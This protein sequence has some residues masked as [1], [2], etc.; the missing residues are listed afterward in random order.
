MISSR[1]AFF[2]VSW[3]WKFMQVR[4]LWKADQDQ[5]KVGQHLANRPLSWCDYTTCNPHLV[6]TVHLPNTS[7][8]TVRNIRVILELC[9]GCISIPVKVTGDNRFTSAE[10]SR[11]VAPP[12]GQQ[13]KRCSSRNGNLPLCFIIIPWTTNPKPWGSVSSCKSTES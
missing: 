5:L 11:R 12:L 7:R 3:A 6:S 4:L 9:F 10:K 13:W 2:G 8:E 1:P